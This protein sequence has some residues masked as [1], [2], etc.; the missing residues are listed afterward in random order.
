[1]LLSLGLGMASRPTSRTL[2]FILFRCNSQIKELSLV[3]P[4]SE[5]AT[6]AQDHY[7]ACNL[8]DLEMVQHWAAR[9][10]N[11]YYRWTTSVTSLHDSLGWISLQD[12]S[13]NAQLQTSARLNWAS[14]VLSILWVTLI[15]FLDL[16]DPRP[17]QTFQHICNCL[18]ELMF[19]NSLF[20]FVQ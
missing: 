7:T 18:P 14:Q 4:L 13:R 17:V 19:I 5:Y 1:M 12:R 9:F 15:D 16:R 3:H 11:K 10:V 2:N 20:F 6:A 8:K